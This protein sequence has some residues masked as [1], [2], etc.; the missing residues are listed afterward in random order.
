MVVLS[1]TG[2]GLAFL[3][4][5]TFL[6]IMTTTFGLSEVDKLGDF[7]IAFTSKGI[8]ILNDLDEDLNRILKKVNDIREISDAASRRCSL[9]NSCLLSNLF[10]LPDGQFTQI[11]EKK[12]KI[13]MVAAVLES[14]NEYVDSRLILNAALQKTTNFLNYFVVEHS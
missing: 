2:A 13:G 10:E 12:N 9:L 6:T 4:T 5:T 1:A 7:E 8:E 11:V 3:Q 14:E